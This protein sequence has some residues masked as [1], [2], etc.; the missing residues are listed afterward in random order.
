MCVSTRV[1]ALWSL[2]GGMDGNLGFLPPSCGFWGSILGSEARSKHL[3]LLGHLNSS[4]LLKKDLFIYMWG[5]GIIHTTMGRSEDK[6]KEAGSGQLN[7]G[8]EHG[9]SGSTVH[10]FPC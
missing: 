10:T 3:Y 6:L 5:A 8:V 1:C 9:S 4:P 7:S 2:C